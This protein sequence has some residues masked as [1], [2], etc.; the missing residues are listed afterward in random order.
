MVANLSSLNKS[1]V[2]KVDKP[3]KVHLPNVNVTL[4][5]FIGSS[6]L[7]NNDVIT[8]VFQVSQ[9]QFNLL[10]VSKLTKE[11]HCSSTFFPNFCIFQDISNGRVKIIGKE[12]G[13]LY[14]LRRNTS[15]RD[16][17]IATSCSIPLLRVD[18]KLDSLNSSID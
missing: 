16:V 13:G 6:V 17:D 18:S 10:S 15:S 5:E 9:F 12:N 2:C 8:G 4:V 11:L 3:K 14:I 7:P 1:T